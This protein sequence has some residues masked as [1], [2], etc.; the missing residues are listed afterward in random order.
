MTDTGIMQLA[1]KLARRGLGNVEPNPMV[2]C[3]IV[4]D[5]AVIGQGFH[6][7]FGGPHAEVNALADCAAKGRDA[8]GAT[9]FV[10]LEP[11]SHRGKTPPCSQAVIDAGVAKVVIAAEDPTDLAGGGINQLKQA[12]IEVEVGLCREEAEKLNAPFYKHARTGLPWVVVKWAQSKDGYLARK[13][14]DIEGDW[15]SNE[16]SRADVHRLRKRMGA[17]LTGIDTVIADD[18]KLTVRIQG[19]TINRPPIRVVVDSHLRMPWD[20]HLITV[21][22]APT[23]VVTTKRTAQT[24]SSKVK[25]L[26]SADVEVLIVGDQDGHCNLQ[27][28]LTLLGS[29]GVQ[30]VLIEAGPTLITESLKHN[31]VDE[32]RIYTAPMILG[33]NGSAPISGPMNSLANQQKLKD[34]RIDT[35]GQDTR[36]CALL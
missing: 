30:Q 25:K 8:K 3:V 24:E 22:D 16:Q 21:S 36:I 9:L 19:E 15:I 23:M 1:L 26:E 4:K 29:R 14:A 20:C 33:D 7:R 31:L 32:A 12:G 34:I 18:P 13:N 28:T 10:T 27:E 11:C 2:G 6:E 5:G 35:F 17:I